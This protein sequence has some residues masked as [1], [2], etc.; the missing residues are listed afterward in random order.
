MNKS[1]TTLLIIAGC[2][3]SLSG[4]TLAQNNSRFDITLDDGWESKLK[5][6]GTLQSTVRADSRGKISAIQIEFAATQNQPHVLTDVPYEIAGDACQVTLTSDVLATAK[7]Q[8]VRI[9]MPENSQFAQVFL[10]YSSGDDSAAPATDGSSNRSEPPPMDNSVMSSPSGITLDDPGS[11][12]AAM[13]FVKLSDRKVVFGQMDL[14][15]KLKFQTKFGEV[16]ISM[17]QVAGIRFHIDGE[18]SALIVLKNGDSVTG[19]PTMESFNLTTDWGRA[20]FE[21]AYVDEITTSQ[22]ASFTRS[23][24][25]QF[26]QRWRLSTGR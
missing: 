21:P 9:A 19:I 26:G 20:E 22:R 1:I 16:D 6:L 23:S 5:S 25:P 17:G 4:S 15:E 14:T 18:D 11:A 13:H 3:A 10:N 12:P 7:L 24:D 2:I 8:P